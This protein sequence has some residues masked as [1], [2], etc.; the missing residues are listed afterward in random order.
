MSII[1]VRNWFLEML[2]VQLL[3]CKVFMVENLYRE[4]NGIMDEQEKRPKDFLHGL[5]I[6]ILHSVLIL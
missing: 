5:G 4:T 1:D 6:D 2:N 3:F